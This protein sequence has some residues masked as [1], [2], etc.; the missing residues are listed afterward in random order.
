MARLG[1]T[2]NGRIS[3]RLEGAESAPPPAGPELELFTFAD[4][5]AGLPLWMPN[6]M[7]I[8]KLEFLA[9]RGRA[10]GRLSPGGD[11][12]YQGSAVLPLAPPVWR[13]HVYAPFDIDGEIL[14]RR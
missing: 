12:T 1:A 7:V 4:V 2:E 14:L 9:L 6:G 13:R 3:D 10:Q 8:H 11:R 5:G